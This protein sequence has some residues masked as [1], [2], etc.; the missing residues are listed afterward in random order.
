MYNLGIQIKVK[1][2]SLINLS[3]CLEDIAVIPHLNAIFISKIQKLFSLQ[4]G[5]VRQLSWQTLRTFMT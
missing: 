2:S 5:D 1:Y 4:L 3:D